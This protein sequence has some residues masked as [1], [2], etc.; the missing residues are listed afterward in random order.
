MRILA[1]VLLATA[2]IT[3]GPPPESEMGPIATGGFRSNGGAL[4]TGGSVVTSSG[5]LIS[6][7]GSSPFGSGGIPS[8][9]GIALSTGGNVLRSG[10]A[11]GLI[12]IGTG[13]S[14]ATPDAAVFTP[15]DHPGCMSEIV[16]NGYSCGAA[17]SCSQCMDN[18]TSLEDK[19][20]TMVNCLQGQWPCSGNCWQ[21]CLNKSGG[22]GVLDTC[23]KA[24]QTAACGG[25][26]CGGGTPSSVDAAV[27]NTDGPMISLDVSVSSSDTAA[28]STD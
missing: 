21:E 4:A 7:G 23:V 22:S 10:G 8:M 2:L 9:G 17:K 19:C 28:D 11:G 20:K 3:C 26:G 24:L 12:I 25:S 14:A 16:G 13:G 1:V 27:M 5:G 15:N 6:T 18:S